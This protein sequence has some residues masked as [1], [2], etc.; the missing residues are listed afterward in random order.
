MGKQKIFP[1]YATLLLLQ[2][3]I[4]PGLILDMIKSLEEIL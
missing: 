4:S 3:G 1:L 2:A